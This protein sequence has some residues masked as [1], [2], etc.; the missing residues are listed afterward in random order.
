MQVTQHFK[1][2]EFT[3][4]CCGESKINL[5]LAIILEDVRAAFNSPVTINSAYR[6][7]QHNK[8]VGGAEHSQHRL[9][10]AADIIVEGILPADVYQWL[11]TRPYANSLGLGKY[12]SFTHIDVRGVVA[13]WVGK[14][15]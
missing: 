11:T 9:G 7:E 8:K 14:H 13:R 2:S 5:A 3:C 15:A 6:C 12:N 4:P 1:K 10:T